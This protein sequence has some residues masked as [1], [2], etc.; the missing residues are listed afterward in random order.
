M[1]RIGE[2]VTPAAAATI[3][4]R[5][6]HTCGGGRVLC[7]GADASAITAA[8]RRRAVEALEF[9]CTPDT[10]VVHLPFAA[11]HFDLVHVDA[12]FDGQDARVQA[13]TIREVLRVTRGVVSVRT[14]QQSR[15]TCERLWLAHGCRKHPLHQGVTP[16][17]E[18]DW[19]Q[20]GTHV[21][22]ERLPPDVTVGR[23]IADLHGGRDLH[24]DMLREA[25]R[26]SDAHVARYAFA[27][28]FIR[29]GD[30]V[31]D[32]ACGLGYGS[33]ILT[34]GTLADSV[35]GIDLD[36]AAVAYATSHYGSARS[37]LSFRTM[38]VQA[39]AD[40]EPESVDVVVTFETLEHLR[41]PD[42]F[43]A[44]CRRALTPAGRLIGSV[45]NMWVDADG[46]DPNPHHLQVF[47][48]HALE[49]LCRRH[50]L[51]EH[52]YGQTA[53]GGMKLPD[54]ARSIW[55]ADAAS[56]DAEWWLIVNMKDPFTATDVPVRD[57][58]VPVVANDSSNIYAFDRDYTAPW[59]S[60]AMVIIGLRATS[61]TLLSHLASETLATT[62]PES[63]DAGA[64][65]CVQAYRHLERGEV[66]PP[67]L[68][69]RIARYVDAGGSVPHVLR[70]RVSLGYVAAL[71]AIQAGH[72][73]TAVR[74]LEVCATSD[75]LTFSPHLATK[76]VGAAFLLGWIAL[77]RRDVD[78]A[79]QWWTHGV[80]QAE[81][82]LHCPWTDFVMARQSPALFGLREAAAIVDAASQCAS[83]LA[84]IEHAPE[85]PGI[86]AS[87]LFESLQEQARRASIGV[88]AA[89][90]P[91]MDP[92]GTN[93]GP[94]AWSLLNH[95]DA[96]TRRQGAPEQV[97]RWHAAINGVPS[98]A[99]LLHPPITVDVTIP[100]ACAGHVKT[101]VGIHPDAWTQ[102]GAAGCVF[103]I[104]GDDSVAARVTL[105]PHRR[106]S[107]RRWV[108]LALDL[109]ASRTGAHVIT[110]STEATNGEAFAWALFRDL[111]FTPDR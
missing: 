40:L 60:R 79:R 66:L 61:D 80:D 36:P 1:D 29:P 91:A 78:A 17:N 15:E 45:P 103:Q 50:F 64:A 110:L 6:L 46:R 88:H 25:G 95:M 83:G 100:Y 93:G 55:D 32:A 7:V 75:A 73:K 56:T 104:V 21:L 70:W 77:Q 51:V 84:L 109:P 59:L 4:D 52:T 99:L 111:A 72:F 107:D 23:D 41:D 92:H 13:D 12:A 106:D 65:L 49:E 24:M 42:A 37:R 67:D 39:V 76:T 57:R 3:V 18:L 48:R 90:F 53:G 94:E 20:A 14:R 11:A 16:Y 68:A 34:D 85:R 10:G 30:R 19:V 81:R 69:T 33:A 38:D 44:A 71:S 63:A 2:Q 35:V 89:A 27:T 86:V 5:I 82:V 97:A 74:R 54:A 87:Q 31:L 28:R 98:P 58:L 102:P 62:D 96:M 108:E 101:A 8:F 22:F 105:D 47:D 9:A 43:L 26:R